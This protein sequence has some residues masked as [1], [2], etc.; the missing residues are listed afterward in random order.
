VFG[1]WSGTSF[2]ATLLHVTRS[3]ARW[4][5]LAVM[6]VGRFLNAAIADAFA[7]SPKNPVKGR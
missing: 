3:H 6:L 7:L 1:L 4:L 5:L 2:E